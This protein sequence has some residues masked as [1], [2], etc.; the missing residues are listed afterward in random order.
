VLKL[1][2]AKAAEV[3]GHSGADPVGA[4]RAFRD[5]GFDSLGSIE[6]RNRLGAATGLGLSATLVFDHP[7]PAALAEHIMAEL[8]PADADGEEDEAEI[9]SLLASV[10]L[11]QLREIGVLERLRA[12]AGTGNGN[13]DGH[14]SDNGEGAAESI[15]AM[16]VDDL[17]RAAMSGAS[18]APRT[19]GA[20]Q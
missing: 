10:S 3:L 15:D 17:V 8:A 2:R 5:L 7:T 12:L 4:D 9:R 13:R 20:D 19:D 1:V 6:L 16:D 11:A 14:R 18:P